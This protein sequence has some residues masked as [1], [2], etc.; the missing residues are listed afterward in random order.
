MAGET[1]GTRFLQTKQATR[2]G[3]DAFGQASDGTWTENNLP[4]YNQNGSLKDSGVA[5]SSLGGGSGGGGA[6]GGP[7]ALYGQI[8]RGTINGSNTTFTTDYTMETPFGMAGPWSILTRN[9][10]QLS[11][12]VDGPSQNST[13]EYTIAAPNTITFV[14]APK[15]TDLIYISYLAGTPVAPVPGPVIQATGIGELVGASINVNFPAGA[16]AGDLAIIHI[17]AAYNFGTFPS[18]WTTN[19]SSAGTTWNGAILSK[20]L[21]SGDI[22][23]G[24]VTVTAANSFEMIYE[25]VVFSGSTS[26]IIEADGQLTATSVASMTTTASAVPGYIAIYFYSGR[27][28]GVMTVNRGALQQSISDGTAA[29]VL[30]IENISAFGVVTAT[31]NDTLT[32]GAGGQTAIVLVAP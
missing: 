29:G 12:P 1:T 5:L 25:I 7:P 11:P 6:T 4:I 10:V 13:F 24:H 14:V 32:I 28:A 31:F 15:V 17:A 16:A 22:S 23:T 20:I 8:P 30:Y 9:G 3:T 27:T 19:Y 26:G 18:G 2:N 21:T